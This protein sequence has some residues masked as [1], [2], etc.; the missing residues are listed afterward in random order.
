MNTRRAQSTVDRFNE[1]HPIGT[2][3]HYWPGVRE[4]EGQTGTTTHP[5]LLLGGVTPVVWIEGALGCIALTHV[6]VPR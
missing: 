5:A 3:V 6:K 4:G 2:M 1:K